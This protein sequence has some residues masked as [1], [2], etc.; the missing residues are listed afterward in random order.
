MIGIKMEL[1]LGL[2]FVIGLIMGIQLGIIP[3]L[4]V[5]GL[6]I[7]FLNSSYVKSQEIGALLFMCV[8]ALVILG[9]AAGDMYVYIEYPELRSNIHIYNLFV[10]PGA[11]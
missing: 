1:L 6:I 3:Q 2:G 7:L 9:M 5:A 10:P 11:K 4:I 8:G